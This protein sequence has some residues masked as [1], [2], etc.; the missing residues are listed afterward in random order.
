M[1][2]VDRCEGGR[3]GRGVRAWRREPGVWA[4]LSPTK[5]TLSQ[6]KL[7]RFRET[8]E[9]GEN[10]LVLLV[11]SV[12]GH[13]FLGWQEDFGT[14]RMNTCQVCVSV[15]VCVCVWCW[16]DKRECVCSEH[17][18]CVYLCGSLLFFVPASSLLGLDAVNPCVTLT[19][20][21]PL[22]RTCAHAHRHTRTHTTGVYVTLSPR[23]ARAQL[24][25]Q[26]EGESGGS[27]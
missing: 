16:E 19:L 17:P 4:E 11:F 5:Q 23:S 14:F 7:W 1:T 10:L 3:W 12:R 25:W 22:T 8:R 9:E 18:M 27:K 13:L 21:P 6:W 24:G 2:S 15:C 26:A 20:H